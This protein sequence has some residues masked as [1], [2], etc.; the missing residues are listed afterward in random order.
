MKPPIKVN[1]DPVLQDSKGIPLKFIKFDRIL[2]AEIIM[3]LT[4]GESLHNICSEDRMPS[5]FEVILWKKQSPDFAS[6]LKQGKKIRAEKMTEDLV[7]IS[8][9]LKKRVLND[10]GKINTVVVEKLF[11][12]TERVT[13]IYDDDQNLKSNVNTQININ[14]QPV[15][16]IVSDPYKGQG[17]DLDLDTYRVDAGE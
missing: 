1:P 9:E 10:E 3:R 2:A 16:M 7:S 4:E 8:S 11:K 14:K 12:I 15:Q 5:F 17:E 13:S 6:M